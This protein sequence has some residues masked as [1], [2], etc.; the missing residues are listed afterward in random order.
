MKKILLLI[1][2]FS[3]TLF[4]AQNI[5][6]TEFATGLSNTVEIAN[7]NDTRLFVVQQDG[8]IKIVQPNGTVN[9]TPF[10]NISTKITFNGERGL[11][12]LAFHP[13]T[14]V[15]GISLCIITTLPETLPLQDIR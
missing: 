6:L 10:L 14:L 2:M 11:L 15:T 3:A 5:T 13:N 4:S 12:G 9:A 7:T 1:G 8:L